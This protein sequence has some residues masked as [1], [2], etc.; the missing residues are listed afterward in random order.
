MGKNLAEI[1]KTPLRP[2][3][4]MAIQASNFPRCFIAYREMRK[5]QRENPNTAIFLTSYAMGDV[6]YGL[7]YLRAWKARHPGTRITLIA[8]PKLKDVIESYSGYDDVVYYD[9]SEKK[10]FRTLVLLNRS[11]YYSFKGQREQIFNTVPPRVYGDK[12]GNNCLTLLKKYLDLAQDTPI[13]YPQPRAAEVTAIPDFAR[14]RDRVAVVNAYS[15]SSEVCSCGLEIMNGVVE[16]L[17]NRGYIVYSNVIGNQK[18]L[19]GTLPLRCG[20]GELY[21]IADG[22]PIFVTVRSGVVDWLASTKSKKFILYGPKTTEGF[23]RMYEMAAW[24][25]KG[26]REAFMARMSSQEILCQL[27]A[28]AEEKSDET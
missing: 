15:S 26:Y 12:T 5:L 7:S 20:I 10:G 28:W 3:K 4:A 13:E 21:W 1:I 19:D 16:T 9:M 2:V 8:G 23:A 17:R 14:V 22:I 27:G 6:V 24:Q 11:K 25:T 18:P